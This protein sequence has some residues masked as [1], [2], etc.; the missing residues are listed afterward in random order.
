MTSARGEGSGPHRIAVQLSHV[1]YL[2]L[3]RFELGG[4]AVKGQNFG[5]ITKETGDVF[6]QVRSYVFSCFLVFSRV[7]SCF[8]VFSPVFSPVFSCVLVFSPVLMVSKTLRMC[9]AGKTYTMMGH[10]EKGVNGI[11][12]QAVEDIFAY[13]KVSVTTS[14]STLPKHTQSNQLLINHSPPLPP[15]TSIHQPS[16]ITTA[17]PSIIPHPS[18]I[19]STG[20]N[21]LRVCSSHLLPGNLQ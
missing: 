14:T 7:F 8:L 9:C 16:P 19:P 11:S 4:L 15:S 21:H 13:F 1:H 20:T 6:K 12:T 10:K 5:V 3:N 17:H 2:H 18:P